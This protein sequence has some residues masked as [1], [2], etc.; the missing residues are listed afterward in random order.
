[1]NLINRRIQDLSSDFFQ[2]IYSTQ[3]LLFNWLI[4]IA[5]KPTLNTFWCLC[6]STHFS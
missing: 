6:T 5:L 4:H 1:M 3:S 2:I